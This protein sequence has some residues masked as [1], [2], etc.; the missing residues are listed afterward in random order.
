MPPTTRE[1]KCQAARAVIDLLNQNPAVPVLHV[2]GLALDEWHQDWR[3]WGTDG[4]DDLHLLIRHED[5]DRFMDRMEGGE[6]SLAGYRPPGTVAR[7][8][9]QAETREILDHP[10]GPHAAYVHESFIGQSGDPDVW[11]RFHTTTR[12]GTLMLLDLAD[13]LNHSESA[14]VME[15]LHPD[16][17]VKRPPLWAMLLWQA[18]EVTSYAADCA[19]TKDEVDNLHVIAAHMKRKEWDTARDTAEEYDGKYTRRVEYCVK[20]LNMKK[21]HLEYGVLYDLR[22][23]LEALAAYGHASG[24]Q[25]NWADLMHRVQAGTGELPRRIWGYVD[26][27]RGKYIPPRASRGVVG[28]ADIGIREQI[29]NHGL[30]S[31]QD[32]ETAGLVHTVISD[33]PPHGP[34]DRCKKEWVK[35]IF[36]V[37]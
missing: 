10:V 35:D 23:A 27:K 18:A 5:L 6:Y 12:H 30:D 7:L 1:E 9:R 33:A 32:L 28:T 21:A 24:Y 15:D 8:N 17:T 11:A 37:V 16:T 29:D 36:E 25:T 34:W 20:T 13:W 4:S 22:Y 19:I 26:A 14:P 2:G 3:R 31:Y